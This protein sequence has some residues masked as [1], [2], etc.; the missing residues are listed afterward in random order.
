[1]GA[2][3]M[4]PWWGSTKLSLHGGVALSEGVAAIPI[5]LLPWRLAGGV[6]FMILPAAIGGDRPRSFGGEWRRPRSL[7]VDGEDC[8]V[9][10]DED[11]DAGPLLSAGHCFGGGR[12]FV[13]AGLRPLAEALAGCGGARSG[14][15]GGASR[16]EPRTGGSPCPDRGIA[17]AATAVNVSGPVG[18]PPEPTSGRVIRAP[19]DPVG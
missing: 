6:F 11:E 15:V 18:G 9:C 16:L 13:G 8:V 3:E 1:M 19:L 14:R 7:G 2:T 12:L 5:T 17:L 4:A 10:E